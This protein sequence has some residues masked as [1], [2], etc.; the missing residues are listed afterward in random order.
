MSPPTLMPHRWH[1]S[2]VLSAVALVATAQDAGRV[3]P[4]DG[5]MADSEPA[6]NADFTA[7]YRDFTT[8]ANKTRIAQTYNRPT[9]ER[10]SA[11][12]YPGRNRNVPDVL[13]V[14]VFLKE[15]HPFERKG[16]FPNLTIVFL[17]QDHCSGTSPGMPTPRAGGQP[18]HRAEGGRQP[19]LQPDVGAPYDGVYPRP[20]ADE[21][22]RRFGPGDG[23]VLHRPTEPDALDRP[24]GDEPCS[25]SPTPPPIRSWP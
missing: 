22:T 18:V 19:V 23:R 16:E 3:G 12:D 7:I 8:K 9:L 10:Y 21:S 25:T 5:E 14:E 6:G 20:A 11:P 24:P 1:L 4:S 15:F 13:R 2:L 17:P